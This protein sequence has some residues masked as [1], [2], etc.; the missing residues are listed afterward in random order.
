MVR[1]RS[2]T[3]IVT[4]KPRPS[5]S[6]QHP[7]R[8][9]SVHHTGQTPKLRNDSAGLRQAAL[10]N[11]IL[12]STSGT[13]VASIV[14]PGHGAANHNKNIPMVAHDPKPVR[15]LSNRWANFSINQGPKEEPDLA[16]PVQEQAEEESRPPAKASISPLT[17]VQTNTAPLS[18]TTV[19]TFPA[20]P[21]T[22]STDNKFGDLTADEAKLV[23]SRTTRASRY[24]SRLSL[25][26]N[27]RKS[28]H[29]SMSLLVPMS[30]YASELDTSDDEHDTEHD[31]HNSETGDSERDSAALPSSA[32]DLDEP[33]SVLDI[34]KEVNEFQTLV[35][36]NSP[37]KTHF[38]STRTQQKLLDLK[39]LIAEERGPPTRGFMNSLD[40]LVK[41]QHEA[42]IS[43][44]TQ[45]RLR[46][47]SHLA[48]KSGTNISCK[49]GVLGFV[50][51]YRDQDIAKNQDGFGSPVTRDNVGDYLGE[52]WAEELRRL[53]ETPPRIALPTYDEDVDV[54]KESL[55]LMSSM[56][57]SVM[58]SQ[59]LRIE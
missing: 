8:A 34:M 38:V 5:T 20:T 1:A 24:Y 42:I 41:I 23:A 36:R 10:R 11:G 47:A 18:Q 54:Y 13:T 55:T 12:R 53:T 57:R 35:D 51:R 9:A 22:P 56:A 2:A 52:L 32:L 15:N 26:V 3:S 28:D 45:I 43:E 58:L 37:Q 50:E 19:T 33:V 4:E 17:Y 31:H 59:D 6:T 30:R 21:V 40:Y 44:W 29:N 46:F 27:D 48:S 39:E 14:Q 7:Q 49:A 16:I 25:L